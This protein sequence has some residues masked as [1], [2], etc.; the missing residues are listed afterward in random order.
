M[1]ETIRRN[2]KKKARK[3]AE[4]QVYDAAYGLLQKQW[5]VV[6]AELKGMKTLKKDMFDNPDVWEEWSTTFK[7]G[8][9]EA[10][11][12]AAKTIVTPEQEYWHDKNKDFEY[13]VADKMRYYANTLGIYIDGITANTQDVLRTGIAEWVVDPK[14]DWEALEARMRKLFDEKRARSIAITETTRLSALVMTDVMET[15]GVDHWVWVP[16]YENTCDDC[17]S[18]AS[19]SPYKLS[20]YDIKP[21]MHPRCNCEMS[22]TETTEANAIAAENV[23]PE[24]LSAPQGDGQYQEYADVDDAD[25]ALIP[26]YQQWADNLT[27]DEQTAISDYTGIAYGGINACAR[28]EDYSNPRYPDA[29]KQTKLLDAA[30]DKTQ[31]PFDVL[32]K[33]GTAH[34][35]L[36]N[37]IENGVVKVGDTIWDKGFLSTTAVSGVIDDFL[38]ANNYRIEFNIIAKA[39][40]K[41]AY[42]NA[43]NLSRINTEA[44]V[45]LPRN[46]KITITAISKYTK[47]NRETMLIEGTYE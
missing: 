11:S 27:F 9:T 31:L 28:D 41:A 13:D 37:D 15:I 17:A 44:E 34:E 45:L 16:L 20:D 19:E 10:F 36:Y 46:A 22:F 40:A 2:K 5:R 3:E 21:P 25:L 8:M 47:N 23:P 38:S 33:R 42:L 7:E 12:R 29:A 24:P 4:R 14:E 32:L 6:L 26:S 1:K 35:P 39:G 30:I 43:N 18:K